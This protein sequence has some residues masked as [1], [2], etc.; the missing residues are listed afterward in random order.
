MFVV[1]ETLICLITYIEEI[2]MKKI[3]L[4]LFALLLTICS[5]CS[6]EST[7]TI[8]FTYQYIYSKIADDSEQ[9]NT[10]RY[11]VSSGYWSSEEISGLFY[12]NDELMQLKPI[13]GDQLYI[14]Y[15]G[16]LH[17]TLDDIFPSCLIVSDGEIIKYSVSRANIISFDETDFERNE[18]GTIVSI[19]SGY[20]YETNV[21][22][23]NSDKTCTS[24][25]EYTGD[26]LYAS[27]YHDEDTAGCLPV[28]RS[29]AAFFSFAPNNFSADGYYF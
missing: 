4:P 25:N 12:G 6:G 16:T 8:T 11:F 2:E 23:I 13:A 28:C 5:G 9:S 20:C 27:L 17:S 7:K 24:L 21:L 14:E 29:I 15:S 10:E 18:E 3:I 1:I 19:Y 22:V 26:I